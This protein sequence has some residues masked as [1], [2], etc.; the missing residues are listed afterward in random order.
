MNLCGQLFI[1]IIMIIIIIC[2]AKTDMKEEFDV[3]LPADPNGMEVKPI[4]SGPNEMRSDRQGGPNEMRSDRQ[5]GPNEMRSDRQGGLGDTRSDG[6]GGHGLR[7]PERGIVSSTINDYL[8]KPENAGVDYADPSTIAK[9]KR[10]IRADD[11]REN[12]TKLAY[13]DVAAYRP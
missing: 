4:F 9:L 7:H 12:Q 6:Q 1:V 8:G 13:N 2:L 11:S 10:T 3:I 5:G